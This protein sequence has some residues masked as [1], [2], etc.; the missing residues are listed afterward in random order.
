MVTNIYIYIYKYCIY[1]CELIS[2]RLATAAQ[3]EDAGFTR[4]HNTKK[5]RHV[6]RYIVCMV[7]VCTYCLVSSGFCN[8]PH[9]SLSIY[10][11]TINNQQ[12]L[13][14]HSLL[15]NQPINNPGTNPFHTPATNQSIK[16]STNRSIDRS[17]DES[18]APT[19]PIIQQ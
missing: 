12:S 9:R 16:Q 5:Q 14:N 18:Q 13:Y 11:S 6:P 10:Q 19:Q 1:I 17:N 8:S 2:L 4:N 7:F 15:I 3:N